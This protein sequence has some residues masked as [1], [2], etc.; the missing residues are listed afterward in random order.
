MRFIPSLYQK[1]ESRHSQVF[2]RPGAQQ[3]YSRWPRGEVSWMSVD[4]WWVNRTRFVSRVGYSLAI[5]REWSSGT[6][7][8]RMTLKTHQE[9]ETRPGGPHCMCLFAWNAQD[10]KPQTPRKPVVA[11]AWGNRELGSWFL[12]G[13]VQIL[14]WGSCNIVTTLNITE[15]YTLKRLNSN[16]K[17]T[18]ILCLNF[19][20]IH[21]W[22]QNYRKTL[23]ER[24]RTEQSLSQRCKN[25]L[26]K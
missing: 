7:Y 17:I 19:S 8:T 16:I 26:K 24:E 18:W 25:P 11:Q 12:L 13:V 23:Q 14:W 1:G 21:Q 20:K 5:K 6:C 22:Y 15:W 9:K 10:R 3:Y 4:T 2:A